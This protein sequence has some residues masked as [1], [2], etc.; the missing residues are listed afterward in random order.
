M[1]DTSVPSQ[2]RTTAA[3][4][5]AVEDADFLMRDEMRATR[6]ALEYQKVDLAMRDWR[7]DST[8]TILGSARIQSQEEAE[9]GLEVA[10]ALAAVNSPGCEASVAEA[11]KRLELSKWYEV[12][13]EFGRIVAERGG[14]LRPYGR[15]Q[16]VVLTGGGPGIMEAGNRGAAEAGAPTVGMTIQ[17]EHEEAPNRWITPGLDFRFH[18]FHMRKFQMF[19][20]ASAI[21]AFPGGYGTFEELFEALTLR[22]CQKSHPFQIVVFGREWWEKAFDAGFLADEGVISRRDLDLFTWA[23]TAEQGWEA[24]LRSGLHLPG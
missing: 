10:E 17:L 2:A 24:L 6:F 5:L 23:E 4:R 22:Q 8:V 18:Y 9:R 12:A 7:I 20:R 13:R 14:S 1:P 19:M 3:Y 15:R 11:R 21:A 16:N